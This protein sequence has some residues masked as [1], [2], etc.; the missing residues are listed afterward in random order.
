MHDSSVRYRIEQSAL[1][2]ILFRIMADKDKP[3]NIGE[4]IDHIERVREELLTI[5]HSLEKIES[6]ASVPSDGSKEST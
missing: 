6:A 2:G 4:L 5:Q 3:R 1:N